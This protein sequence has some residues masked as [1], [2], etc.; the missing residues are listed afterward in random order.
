MSK[1]N[2]DEIRSADRS[3][4]SSANMTFADDG[5]VSLGGTLSA[6]TIGGGVAMAS[7]GL[8]V[9]NIEQVALSSTQSLENNGTLTTF[10][11]PTYDPKISGSKVCGILTLR[12]YMLAN[13][14]SNGRKELRMTFTGSDITDIDFGDGFTDG[15]G[16]YDYGGSGVIIAISQSIVGP[17][18]TTTGTSTITCN[19]K[20][21]NQTTNSGSSWHAF[22]A[23]N[24]T[25]T[26][27]TWIEYK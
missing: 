7:S 22:G 19:C 8:T 20:L 4:S 10:F 11:S 3:T 1:L 23:S 2:V 26:F 16:S 24:F 9:R 21:R 14:Y 17:L 12:G 13:G 15:I 6:G 5:N 18:V 25:A 27:F